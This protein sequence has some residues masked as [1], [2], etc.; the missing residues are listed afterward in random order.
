MALDVDRESH[1]L[2]FPDGTRRRLAVDSAFLHKVQRRHFLL[3]DALPLVGTLG[4]LALLPFHPI[5]AVEISL[6][7][8]MWLLTGVGITVGFHRLFAHRSF[9]TTSAVRVALTIFGCMAGRGPMISWAAMHRRHHER[10]DREGDMHSP[11]MH[12]TRFGDRVRGF[13]H[14]HLTWMAKHEYPNVNHYV[15]DLIGDKPVLRANRRYGTWVVLG[16]VGPAVVGGLLTQSLMGA[17]TTFLWAGVVRMFV[18]EQS[19][20]AL[21]S[22][23][24][25]MGRRRFHLGRDNSR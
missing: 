16:L 17:L 14:A 25:V 1:F 5:G 4:A 11:N 6:A 10:A 23:L 13:V 3:Y 22:F 2:E 12:G 8:V 7:V 21:N 9:K 15:P 18:V 20:S 24:H 19:M